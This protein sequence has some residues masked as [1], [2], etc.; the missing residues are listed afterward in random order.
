M[1]VKEINNIPGACSCMTLTSKS[2]KH[3]WFRTC[4]IET[5]LWKDG[6][7]VVWQVAGGQ[8]QYC[9][10]SKEEA[11]YAYLGMTYN[12]LDT[13]MLD[14]INQRG[15]TGG[16]LMLYEG[17]SVDKPAK[18]KMGY[19]G[20]EVVTKLLSSCK[21][22]KE[23]I[24]LT[25]QIQILNIPYKDQSVAATMHY[26]FT[27]VTG[28]EVVLEATDV[29]HPGILKIYSR[30]EILGVMT[31]SPPYDRQLENLSWFLSRSPE[32][33][34]GIGKHA[35]TE[36]ILDGRIIRADEKAE[37]ISQN[38]TFPGSYSSYDRFLRAAVIKAVND[39]GN[40]FED[41]KMLALGSNLMSSLYEPRNGGLYHYTKIE[42]DGSIT[43]Q[44]DSFTQY[45]IMYDLEKTCFYI[46][47]Y[48]M[49]SWIEYSFV[50]LSYGE[51][52]NYEIKHHSMLG[53]LKG[54][55]L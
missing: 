44:K 49:V 18:G 14:G 42:E 25:K 37:H 30:E 31:N 41:H 13:W 48:D 12:E 24:A 29:E 33:Q 10:G 50:D 16:L 52:K 53:I 19:V 40:L 47:V 2:G 54:T 6:A 38:G 17:T 11:T 8:I 7:H 4:D 43:G 36:L 46:K 35:V 51:K 1:K 45:L 23:V 32:L 55:Q 34:Q 27:D 15:L 22:V 20:M 26:F 3:Y 39:S 28:N 5:D 9:N 21:D